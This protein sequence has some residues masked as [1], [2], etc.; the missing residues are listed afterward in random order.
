VH[1]VR[2]ILESTDPSNDESGCDLEKHYSIISSTSIRVS[3]S[4]ND[5][6]E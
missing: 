5:V 6:G 4:E 2:D 1:S 3:I